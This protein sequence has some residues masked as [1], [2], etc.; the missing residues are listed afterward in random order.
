[1]WRICVFVTIISCASVAFSGES[2]TK[3]YD[4]INEAQFIFRVI[5]CGK[6]PLPKGI[7]AGF[8]ADHCRRV[9][10]KAEQYRV[11][12]IKKACPFIAK[13]R[14]KN[15]PRIV[16][17]PFGGGDLLTALATY[18]DAI[19]ITTISLE[20]AGDPRR[21]ATVGSAHLREALAQFSKVL[22]FLLEEFDSSNASIRAS[23]RSII[24]GQLTFSLVAASIYG[25]EPVSLKYF[26]LN[27]DGTLHY[28]TREDIASVEKTKA[29]KLGSTWVDTDFSIAFRNM[30]LSLR[31]RSSGPGSDVIIHRH[32]A[33]NLHNQYFTASPLQKHLEQKGTIVAMTKAASYLL[34]RSDFSAIRNY[35]LT[36]MIFMTSDST[37]ILPRHANAAG[38][39]QI[40]Y[41]KFHGAFLDNEGG[42]DAASLRQLWQSQ[43]YRKLPFRYGHSDIR[44]A[45][46][47]L[48]TRRRQHR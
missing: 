26:S 47:L 35:L 28:L 12:F 24:P 19:E 25:Y 5:S 9:R 29:R 6:G 23:E 14:P 2:T 30:E 41:G 11:R 46:H 10:Q 38:F 33:A 45:N 4:F 36:H 39:E 13:V 17:Y 22:F 44:G 1:M 32:I 34:W 15:L 8:V 48:I 40:T 42:A 7:E 20:S 43:P 37:G 18:P 16:I 21:P 3:G 27:P 31:R